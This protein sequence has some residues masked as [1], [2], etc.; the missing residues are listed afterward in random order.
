MLTEAQKKHE[1]KQAVAYHIELAIA[2]EERYQDVKKRMSTVG[3]QSNIDDYLFMC[4]YD[5]T[6]AIVQ[7]KAKEAQTLKKLN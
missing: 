7:Q 2:L 1:E 4:E 6:Q 3:Y 5:K